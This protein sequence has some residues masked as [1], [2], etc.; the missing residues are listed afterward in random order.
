M[1]D[2]DVV[3]TAIF[4]REVNRQSPSRG[5]AVPGKQLKSSRRVG[6]RQYDRFDF[7]FWVMLSAG[8]FYLIIRPL[9][10]ANRISFSEFVTCRLFFR[11]FHCRPGRLCL[12]N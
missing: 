9:A 1:V 2:P 4:A 5:R 7:D 6:P 8:K 11:Q 12:S 10:R 3:R